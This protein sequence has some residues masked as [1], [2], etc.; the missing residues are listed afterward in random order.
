MLC[1]MILCSAIAISTKQRKKHSKIKL[2]VYEREK[3]CVVCFDNKPNQRFDSCGH[4]NSCFTCAMTLHP[5]LCPTCRRPF[6]SLE[7][8]SLNPSII[9]ETEKIDALCKPKRKHKWV[10]SMLPGRILFY[11]IEIMVIVFCLV[12]IFQIRVYNNS[13]YSRNSFWNDS[14]LTHDALQKHLKEID[15]HEM[16]GLD[17]IIIVNA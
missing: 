7:S 10:L 14:L 5:K 11:S 4:I 3:E 15:I 12:A 6:K 17:D 9:Q 1:I 8:V 13:K 16:E 2:E